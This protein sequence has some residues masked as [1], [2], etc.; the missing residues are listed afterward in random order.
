MKKVFTF[1]A[2]AL[3]A[4]CAKPLHAQVVDNF[5][6]SQATNYY[7][8]VLDASTEGNWEDVIDPNIAQD[9]RVN[10]NYGSTTATPPTTTT[11]YYFLDIWFSG[12]DPTYAIT[13][14]E[15]LSGHGPF[16]NA[17]YYDFTA[18][19]AGWGG[20]GFQ[21]L[22]SQT[23]PPVDFTAITDDYRFH[24]DI[25]KTNSFP[26]RIN[27]FG[28]GDATGA[29]DGTKKA[30]FIVGDPTATQI[31]GDAGPLQNLT[32]NFTV[33]TWQVIDIPVSQL[34]TMYVNDGTAQPW[35]NRAPFTGY[36]FE[37]EFGT[38]NSNNL[39]I[40]GVFF[41][42]P[43]NS[44]IKDVNANNKLSVVVTKE[45]V[46]VLNAT[47]PIDVYNLAG[48]KVKTSVQPTF[49][50]DEVSKGAYI[51]KSGNAVAKVI[52]K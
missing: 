25:R 17:T 43:A 40:D 18:Q 3:L 30:Q 16:D 51:I 41:Y 13:P 6:F 1:I 35:D 2:V 31:Y 20:G 19:S 27:V 44:G 9:L 5:D 48:V 45:T 46:S 22:A 11:G 15:S 7:L 24:M 36:Y 32:P 21:A 4:L 34:K 39:S 33:N 29:S 28:T 47:G 52:I 14:S 23:P 42:K 50:V 38:D 26:C 49:G 37:Y 10:G 12:T 8:L